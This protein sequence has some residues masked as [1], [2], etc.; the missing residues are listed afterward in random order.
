MKYYKM[1]GLWT[2][3]ATQLMYINDG[4]KN[5]TMSNVSPFH[6]PSVTQIQAYRNGLKLIRERAGDDVFLSGCAIS[7]NMR[8]FGASFGL[9]DAM[10]VGPDFNHDG[11]GVKTGPLR[12]SR[13]YFLNGKIW[14]NDPDPAKV[15]AN[16][17]TSVADPSANG[18]V[19]LDVARLT[20]TF[21][22]LTGQIFLLSDWLPDLPEERLEVLRR[23]MKSHYATARPVDYF[24]RSLPSVWLISDKKSGVDREVLGLFNWEKTTEAVGSTLQRTGLD[25]E[26]SYFAFDFWNNRLLPDIR[27]SFSSE[28]G[29]ESCSVIA[30]RADEGHPVLLGTSAHVTQGITDV[31]SE[32]W[33]DNSLTGESVVTGKDPYELRIRIPEGWKIIRADAD[34]LTEVLESDGLARIRM[35]P[36]KDGQVKWAVTFAKR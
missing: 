18:A 9:V 1:D 14:W 11:L 34:I 25:P 7:Q 30:L 22:A 3:T 36:E 5:D 27:G 4:Y 33:K 10:R 29:P 26:R 17:G 8:S 35:M 12:A 32:T 21:A 28:L 2:G 6:D 16:D 13:Y 20:S 15:R 24:D 31:L 19:S 23:T